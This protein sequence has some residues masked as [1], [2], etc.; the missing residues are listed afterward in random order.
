[1]WRGSVTELDNINATCD[2]GGVKIEFLAKREMI[3]HISMCSV[4]ETKRGEEEE[5]LE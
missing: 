5:P 2:N 4:K 3:D 1:V